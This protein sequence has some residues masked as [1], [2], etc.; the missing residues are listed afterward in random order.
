MRRPS[1]NHDAGEGTVG[2]QLVR[3]ASSALSSVSSIASAISSALQRGALVS[4]AERQRLRDQI[5]YLRK[6]E[7]AG[8]ISSLGAINMNH[9]FDLHE[10]AER[11]PNDAAYRQ[12]MDVVTQV[13]QLLRQNLDDLGTRL[14]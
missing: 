4:A 14:R 5:E 12:A 11:A 9:L 1:D 8:F 7:V 3:T 2:Q 6:R 13:S 10:R